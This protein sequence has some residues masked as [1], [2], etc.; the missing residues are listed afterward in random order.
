[1]SGTSIVPSASSGEGLFGL[2]RLRGY[3][4]WGGEKS[5][6]KV[7]PAAIIAEFRL[8]SFDGG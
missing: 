7:V 6:L 3:L 2:S 8:A 1:M 4:F 5:P